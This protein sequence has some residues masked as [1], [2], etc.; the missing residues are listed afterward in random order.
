M[1]P[2][3]KD[4]LDTLLS[5]VEL[6]KLIRQ[7]LL[8]E[9]TI[10]PTPSVYSTEKPPHQHFGSVETLEI[11]TNSSTGKATRFHLES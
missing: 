8:I 6:R 3:G 11:S 10:H 4:T 2:I 1:K 5:A 7:Y 9:N